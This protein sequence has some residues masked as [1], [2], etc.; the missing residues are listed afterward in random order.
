[1]TPEKTSDFM[2]VR[3]RVLVYYILDAN[4]TAERFQSRTEFSSFRI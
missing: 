4:I 2:D 3:I 1:M